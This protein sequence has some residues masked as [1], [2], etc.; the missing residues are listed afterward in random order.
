MAPSHGAQRDTLFLNASPKATRTRSFSFFMEIKGL[1]Y[2]AYPQLSS[3]GWKLIPGPWSSWLV[4]NF[5]SKPFLALPEG[6]RPVSFYDGYRMDTVYIHLYQAQ[7]KKL[8]PSG[9]QRVHDMCENKHSSI[10][11]LIKSLFNNYFY[12]HIQ[13]RETINFC[14][15]RLR[16]SRSVP[17]ESNRMSHHGMA[18]KWCKLAARSRKKK[19]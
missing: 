6:M 5:V 10:G 11:K 18:W 8:Q 15:F 17:D 14:W 19:R 3:S 1:Y 16:L 4:L 12:S 13:I 2:L 7:A 9:A